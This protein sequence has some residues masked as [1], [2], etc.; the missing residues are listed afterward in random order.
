MPHR[1]SFS[2]IRTRL[3]SVKETELELGLPVPCGS[4]PIVLTCFSQELF[5]QFQIATVHP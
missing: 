1:H 3:T 4:L 5:V 2:L